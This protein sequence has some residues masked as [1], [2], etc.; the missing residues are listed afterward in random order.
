MR[1]RFAVLVS[2]LTLGAANAVAQDIIVRDIGSAEISYGNGAR[3]K[4]R[5]G[6]TSRVTIVK[7]LIDLVPFQTISVTGTGVRIANLSNGRTSASTGFL[8]MDVTVPATFNTNSTITLNVGLSDRFV[9]SV[10]HR[11]LVSAIVATPQPSTLQAGTPWV[12]TVRGTDLGTPVAN[13]GP[14]ACHNAPTASHFTDS[15]RFTLVRQATCSTNSFTLRID[16]SASDD[17]PKYALASGNTPV[18]GF[19]YI[20]PPPSGV[21]CVS[22]PGLSAPV[23]TAPG[24]LQTIVFASATPSP[25]NIVIRWDSLTNTGQPV[26]NN[27]WIVSQVPLNTTIGGSLLN[28]GSPKGSTF[29]LKALSRTFS[30]AIPGTYK[31]TVRPKNCGQ[32]ALAAAVQFT[33]RY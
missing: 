14:A 5:R 27:E 29:T 13:L 7:D 19:S 18:L 32:N 20:P 24:N 8:A 17:P 10:V 33:I 6:M 4:I 23:I 22:N 3:P 2:A 15:V 30:L 11:G 25:T 28:G 16:P 26:P 1:S 31:F 12:A 21:Q 9:M